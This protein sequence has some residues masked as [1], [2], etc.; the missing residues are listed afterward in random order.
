VTRTTSH[1]AN[2]HGTD[3]FVI[4][5]AFD[6]SRERLWNAFTNVDEIKRWWGPKGV[7]ITT[8]KMDLR[9]D[10]TFHYCMRTP[11]GTD[12]WGRQVYREI[13]KPER[14]VL[15]NSFSDANGGLTRH[16]LAPSWPIEMLSTFLF[17]E[18]AGK[19][20][21]TVNW[22]P[23][24]PTPEERA[25]FDAGHDSMRGGWT[26]TMDQLGAYLENK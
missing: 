21:F 8:A 15:I 24:N 25:A 17:T 23:F 12:M 10:G 3:A 1:A 18:A 9:P 20:T 11:D 22:S 6:C 5:R 2:G 26:G 13:V 14:I 4:S 7:T 19:A 16:P